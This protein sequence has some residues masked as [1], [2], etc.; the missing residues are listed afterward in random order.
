MRRRRHTGRKNDMFYA[1]LM[2]A[3]FAVMVF[4]VAA[5]YFAHNAVLA[6]VA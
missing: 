1:A 2:F 4:N 6:Q 3:I 5:E